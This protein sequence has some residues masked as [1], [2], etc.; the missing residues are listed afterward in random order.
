LRFETTRSLVERAKSRGELPA[1][2]Q[3]RFVL[4]LIGGPIWLR[5]II[6]GEPADNAFLDRVVD[7][8]L[9]GIAA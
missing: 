6:V 2:T 5:T 1:A 4:E 8:A 3:P 7:A 9:R